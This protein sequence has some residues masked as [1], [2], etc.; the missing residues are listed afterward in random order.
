MVRIEEYMKLN[1]KHYFVKIA[2]NYQEGVE[3]LDGYIEGLRDN[4]N[5]MNVTEVEVS[6]F[7]RPLFA[8]HSSTNVST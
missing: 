8:I 6:I 4:L 3:S 7:F 2:G 1:N 5:A